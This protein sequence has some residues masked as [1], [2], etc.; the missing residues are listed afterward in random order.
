[1]GIPLYPRRIVAARSG[2]ED[3]DTPRAYRKY[4]Q[5]V[6]AASTQIISR[7]GTVHVVA[8]RQSKL[9][10]CVL[11]SKSSARSPSSTDGSSA[12]TATAAG[13]LFAVLVS[14]DRRQSLQHSWKHTHD[15]G[16]TAT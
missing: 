11:S 12:G 15:I 3:V 10:R 1:M 8:D 4:I 13:A 14:C 6:N 2:T 16:R 7:T 5:Q 9:Y